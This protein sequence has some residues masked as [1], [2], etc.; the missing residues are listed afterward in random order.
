MKKKEKEIAAFN[1]KIQELEHKLEDKVK[2]IFKLEVQIKKLKFSCLK[3]RP[4][5]SITNGSF[6]P[7]LYRS[8]FGGKFLKICF[9]GVYEA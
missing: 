4:M 6:R 9:G 8:D 3:P 1:S 5:L 2:Y 7:N